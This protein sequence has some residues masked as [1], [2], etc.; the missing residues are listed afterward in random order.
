MSKQFQVLTGTLAASFLMCLITV[1]PVFGQWGHEKIEPDLDITIGSVAQTATESESGEWDYVQIDPYCD[2]QHVFALSENDIYAGGYKTD[3][4]YNGCLY[5]NDGIDWEAVD[6]DGL[7]PVFDIW[8]SAGDDIYVVGL[9]FGSGRYHYDGTNW[10]KISSAT[11][12]SIW[13]FSRNDVFIGAHDITRFQGSTWQT[14]LLPA[15]VNFTFIE[16]IWGT[17]AADVY[18]VGDGDT[19]LYYDGNP[20]GQWEHFD[21]QGLEEGSY[22]LYGIWGSSD[23]DIFVT[24]F[25][26]V[27][28]NQRNLILHYDGSMWTT[29]VTSISTNDFNRL[30]EIWGTGPDDVYTASYNGDILHYDGTAW[31][32]INSPSH[33]VSQPAVSGDNQLSSTAALPDQININSVSGTSAESIYFAGDDGIVIHYTTDAVECQNDS[34]CSEGSECVEGEC[35]PIPDDPPALTAGPFIAAGSWP[36]LSATQQGP[37]YLSQNTS[38]LWT[39]S[40]D[41]ASCSGACTHSAQYSVVGSGIWEDLSVSSDAEAGYAYVELPI[42]SLQNATTYAFRYTVRDC[43]SQST[44]SGEYYFRVAT[45]DAP[46]AITGGPWLAAGAWP[47]LSTSATRAAMLTQN[48]YVLWTFSDD[49]ASCA[50]LCTHRARFRKVGD[51]AWTWLTPVSTDPTGKEYAYTTLPA[52][53]LDAGTYQFYFDVRDCAGQRTLAPK[54][55]Y[56]KVE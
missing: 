7:G 51:T 26:T 35:V 9:G 6:V 21:K 38:L 2:I 24:A 1:A 17:S 36:L 34:D 52:G 56:F 50:G 33:I 23:Q 41:F 13:G 42:A 55:Y 40:D 27:G 3:G 30:L 53:S 45:S 25:G 22:A 11:G 18:A 49:Y 16:G 31:S 46:P 14:M 43:A 8:G 5:H 19:I 12:R 47:L 48:E 15:G 32:V 54:V 10:T 20:A 39:F 29:F 37:T 4:T 28:G 44:H